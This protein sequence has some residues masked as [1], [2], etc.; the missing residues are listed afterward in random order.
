MV[1]L[2]LFGKTFSDMLRDYF[3][4]TGAV[5]LACLL[6][7]Q[8]RTYLIHGVHE[9]TLDLLPSGL[10]RAKI[11]TIISWRPGQHVFVRFF[12]LGLHSL[13][14]HPFTICSIAY[15]PE[16]TGKASEIVFLIK[17]RRG[18]TARLAKVAEKS[19]ACTKKVLLEGPYGGLSETNLAQF[20]QALII[21]GGSGGG[22]S[23]AVAEE[24]LKHPA[25]A[26]GN[27][28]I[29]FST[30]NPTMA[31]WYIEELETKLSTFNA[32]KHTSVSVH[33]TTQ[34]QPQ[35]QPP[36]HNDTAKETKPEPDKDLPDQNVNVNENDNTSEQ[37]SFSVHRQFRP[38]IPGIVAAAAD[39]VSGK[40]VGV[41]VCGPA[42]MLHDTRNAAA[43][44]QRGV[45][46]GVVE[47]VFLHTEPFS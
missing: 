46:R 35:T 10:V 28:Q 5:Y 19:P 40:R 13:T 36:S 33:I 25:L 39:G 18:I 45:L 4:A 24:A 41:F 2:T 3:I 43:M 11:P 7:A 23:L 44:A 26:H 47:E 17:P 38:D 37:Y 30:R 29:I 9:A 27:L 32:S 42:S 8:I 6:A 20:D 12:A 16:E 1:C 31:D 21:A 15:N 14:A 22:F 34:T